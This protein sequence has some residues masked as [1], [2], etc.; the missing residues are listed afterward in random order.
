MSKNDQNY[1]KQFGKQVKKLNDEIISHFQF[2]VEKYGTTNNGFP[3][4]TLFI[5]AEEVPHLAE[6]DIAY[7]AN[8]FFIC[9]DGHY[10]DFNT[11]TI[12]EKAKVI[13]TMEVRLRK[14]FG[15]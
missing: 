8:D 2:L 1:R 7:V 9:Q 3:F 11:L 10:Y 6:I 4:K 14:G 15:Y 12:D 5:K 13:D